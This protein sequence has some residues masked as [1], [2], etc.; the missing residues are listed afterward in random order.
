MPDFGELRNQLTINGT[1][2][3]D[4]LL[5]CMYWPIPVLIAY[6]SAGIGPAPRRHHPH[7]NR[8]GVGL[9]RN[10]PEFLHDGDVMQISCPGLSE[11]RNR[12]RPA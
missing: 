10:P 1:L 9:W 3:Q 12:G 7:W 11:L 8:I 4:F 5:A 6:L 2:K